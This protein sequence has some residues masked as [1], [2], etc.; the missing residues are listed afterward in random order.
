MSETINLVKWIEINY[1]WKMCKTCL[2]VTP[3]IC[4]KQQ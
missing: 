1:D 4:S 3:I 2:K